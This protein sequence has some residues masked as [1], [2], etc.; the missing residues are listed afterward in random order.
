MNPARMEPTVASQRM[1]TASGKLVLGSAS[2]TRMGVFPF[3]S[4]PLTMRAAR[5]VFPTPPFHLPQSYTPSMSFTYQDVAL[6][7]PAAFCS[8]PMLRLQGW[9]RE[10][11]DF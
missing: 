5:V 7:P 11:P 2:T 6:C 9:V 8:S 3:L 4:R 10:P 1:P